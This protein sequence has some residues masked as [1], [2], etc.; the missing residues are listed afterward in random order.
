MAYRHRRYAMTR[1]TDNP[2]D[3]TWR[4]VLTGEMTLPFSGILRK[5]PAAPRCKLCKAPFTGPFA[6]VL[7][8]IGFSRWPLNQQ[9]C[10]MC[11]HKIEDS[12]GGAEVDVS[13]LFADIRGSTELAERL[14]PV[15]YSGL[16]SRYF[17]LAYRAVDDT[18][19]VVDHLVGDG[20]MAMWIPGFS[21]DD[22]AARA[23]TAGRRLLEAV[24]IDEQLDGNLK[25][26]AGVHTGAAFVGVVGTEG[27]V[28]DFTVVGDPAN[29]VARLGSI[30]G[31]G[32]LVVS[33]E[34]A[35]AGGLATD[36]LEHRSLDLKGK[37]EPFGAWVVAAS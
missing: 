7:K 2:H 26:G 36:G 22:H 27:A 12:P 6:P 33:S 37:A 19:G 23:I 11:I 9:L 28:R 32:E 21:G 5:L 29:T 4:K 14:S 24:E 13:L 25:V 34:A 31:P 20:V 3:E 16:V 17:H 10:K 15:V 8:M 18:D 30:A 35:L 1:P